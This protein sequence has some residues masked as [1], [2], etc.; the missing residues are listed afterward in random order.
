MSHGID[1]SRTNSRIMNTQNSG[2][3]LPRHLIRLTR[4]RDPRNT[5]EGRGP[6][7]ESD[8]NIARQIRTHGRS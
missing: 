2:E 6:D 7:R 4:F 1:S 5:F 8:A 3:L